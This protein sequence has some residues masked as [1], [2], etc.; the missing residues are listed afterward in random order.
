[1]L[2]KVFDMI[3]GYATGVFDMFHVGH[4]NLIRNAK[5]NCDYLIVGVS[6]DKMVLEQKKVKL[7]VPY[8]DRAEIISSLKCVDRVVPQENYNKVEAWNIYKFDR[9]FVGDDWKGSER[10]NNL[11]NEFS[12]LGVDI[13]YLPYTREVSSTKLRKFIEDNFMETQRP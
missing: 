12:R 10:W 3:I 11:E 1:M 13:F 7:V 9:I 5:E 6:T 8:E 4:L 2:S